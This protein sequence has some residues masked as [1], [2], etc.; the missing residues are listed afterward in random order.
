MSVKLYPLI[1]SIL[2]LS[3]CN[4]KGFEKLNLELISA[5]ADKSQAEEFREKYLLDLY[6]FVCL[7]F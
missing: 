2:I 7:V 3:G 5:I 4:A 6:N 1:I